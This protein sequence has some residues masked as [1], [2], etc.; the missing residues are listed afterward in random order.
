MSGTPRDEQTGAEAVVHAKTGPTRR[1]RD[2]RDLA[3]RSCVCTS[4]ACYT[5][6]VRKADEKSHTPEHA[7][8]PVMVVML[9]I[10]HSA[11][12]ETPDKAENEPAG[13]AGVHKRMNQPANHTQQQHSRS[14]SHLQPEPAVEY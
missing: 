12:A 5:S 3:G 2:T 14:H 13:H 9:L 11:H 8:S 1:H 4:T 7:E 6:T 10:G